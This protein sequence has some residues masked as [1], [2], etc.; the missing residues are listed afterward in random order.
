[1]TG[2]H[3]QSSEGHINPLTDNANHGKYNTLASG[4]PSGVAYEDEDTSRSSQRAPV[5][6]TQSKDSHFG[7]KAAGLGA[8]AIGAGTPGV[9]SHN[10]DQNQTGDLSRHNESHT[11]RGLDR[12]TESHKPI[13]GA[14]APGTSSSTNKPVIH[15]CK[16]CGVDNDISEYFTSKLPGRN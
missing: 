4:T 7:S 2:S 13:T 16:N 11:E 12:Q 6:T 14:V 1:L 5:D 9:L 10:R 3:S 15:K 8:A